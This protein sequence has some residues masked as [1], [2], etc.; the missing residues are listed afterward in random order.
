MTDSSISQLAVAF[1]RRGELEEQKLTELLARKAEEQQALA[2]LKRAVLAS[3]SDMKGRSGNCGSLSPAEE[4]E[5][6][7]PRTGRDADIRRWR[8]KVLE[9]MKSLERQ[10]AETHQAEERII[11]LEH[12]L[13]QHARQSKDIDSH[14]GLSERLAEAECRCLKAE[15]RADKHLNELTQLRATLHPKTQGSRHSTVKQE[16][17]SDTQGMAAL[18]ARLSEAELRGL[19]AERSAAEAGRKLVALTLQHKHKGGEEKDQLLESYEAETDAMMNA[20]GDA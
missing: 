10:K 1:L 6:S 7:S 8:D 16:S 15:T 20:V 12:A 13:Q 2:Q 5:A 9:L 14:S 11:E 4:R 18:K 19:V 3:V 17:E